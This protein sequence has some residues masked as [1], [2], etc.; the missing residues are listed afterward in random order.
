MNII[1]RGIR[2]AFRNSIRTGSI[3]IILSISIGLVIAMLSARQAVTNKIE[4]VKSSVG[5]TISVSP[6]GFRGMDGGGT[7]LTSEQ[8]AKITALD[9]VSSV[10]SSLTDR[11]R[12][13]STTNLESGV[14]AGAL[15]SRPGASGSSGSNNSDVSSNSTNNS[16]QAM[17]E[18]GNGTSEQGGRQ[19]GGNPMTSIS[20]TGINNTSSVSSFGGSSLT[21]TSGKV[22]DASADTDEAVVGKV[23]AEKNDLQVGDTF[24]AYDKTITVVGI[25][26]AGTTFANN[27]VFVS[28]ST[29]QRISDQAD[30]ITSVSVTVDSLD[31]LSSTTTAIKSAVGSDSIDVTNNQETADNA[32]K[33]LESVQTISLYS[34]IG[35]IIAGSVIILLTMIM[36]VR[37]R[38]R[39][40]G[41]MKAIGASNIGIT[42]QFIVEAMTLT[43]LGLI[44][45]TV[46]GIFASAPLA[47]MLVS[48]SSS[49]TT[50]QMGPGGGGMGGPGRGL[51]SGIRAVTDVQS[52]VGLSTLGYG[53]G[54]TLLITILG[55][56]IPAMLIS[57]VKPAEAMRSE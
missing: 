1:S 42:G 5:N 53:T 48:T 21:W 24:T 52:S 19:G 47:D 11:L 17:P 54:A 26:D 29:L 25:Y 12:T 51:T 37:E 16:S 43:A 39:E 56:A 18:G 46:I 41:V 38:R 3:V 8:I 15:G 10:T 45:G 23:L 35:A 13:D 40:I 7:A 2:N 57:K 4:T 6:A 14:E 44:V 50:S 55:S 49:S 33:P 28:L 27:G 31:N 22:F 30:S 36:I 34:L 32:V 20:I 9:H